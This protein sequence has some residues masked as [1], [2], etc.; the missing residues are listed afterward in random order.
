MGSGSCQVTLRVPDDA[1]AR[2]RTDSMRRGVDFGI[3]DWATFDDGQSIANP[4]W[5][6]TEMPKLA[7]LQRERARKRKGSLRFKRLGRRI[8]R[9][10]DRIGNLRR[11]FVH[12]ETTRMVQSCA[13]L[14]TEALAPKTMSRS[15]ARRA[16]NSFPRRSQTACM[17]VRTAGTSCRATATAERWCSSTRSTHKTRLERAWRRD[18]NLGHGNVASP[19]L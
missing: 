7:A 9:L 12:K 16:G 1:C 13:V 5:L 18:P 6:R 2:Q 17:S 15:A 14:A 19:G 4:R 3:T 11:D 8:A 10:H